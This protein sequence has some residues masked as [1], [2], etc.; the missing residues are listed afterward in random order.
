MLAEVRKGF[1]KRANCSRET[2]THRY[3]CVADVLEQHG[4]LAGFFN[5]DLHEL[6]YGLFDDCQWRFDYVFV[7][8]KLRFIVLEIR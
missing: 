3:Q 6:I 2:G 8:P 7:Y 4:L 1:L 5:D